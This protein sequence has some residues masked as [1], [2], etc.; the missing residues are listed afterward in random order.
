MKTRMKFPV[1]LLLILSGFA[2]DS[3]VMAH[4]PHD[5]IS[6]ISVSPA[7]ET[8]H[9]VFCT[10]RYNSGFIL[11][12]TNGGETWL[13]SQTGHPYSKL[14][15]IVLSPNYSLDGE[16]FVGTHEGMI[17]KSLNQGGSWEPC[18]GDAAYSI[19]VLAVSP[20]YA[21]DSVVLFGTKNHG[22]FMSSDG[23][24]TWAA[25]N[26][27]LDNK[28]IF[29][30][31]VSPSFDT[32]QTIFS[33]TKE[34]IFKS[35]DGG[36]TWFNPLGPNQYYHVKS[37]SVSPSYSLDQTLFAAVWGGGVFK[38][39]DGGSTWEIA[40]TGITDLNINAVDLSPDYQND[41]TLLVA[42][43]TDGIFKSTDGGNSWFSLNEG[44][45]EKSSQTNNHYFSFAFSPTYDQDQTVFLATWEGLHLSQDN[46]SKWRHLNIFNQNLVRGLVVSPDF[47]ND[48]TVFAATYGGGVY[49]TEDRGES[50]KAVDTGLKWMFPGALSIS[51][52]FTSDGTLFTGIYDDVMKSTSM[53]DEWVSLKI[54]YQEPWFYCKSLALSPNYDT[55]QT[56][57]AG[58]GELATNSIYKSIDGGDSFFSLS[59]QWGPATDIA[60]SPVYAE[61]Q[62]V[63]TGTTE[64]LYRSIDGGWQWKRMTPTN[65]IVT[66]LAVSP[67]FETDGELF[68]AVIPYDEEIAPG[69]YKST[70]RG[71][72]WFESS[73]GLDETSVVSALGI[74]P[75]YAVDRTLFAATISKG[76]YKSIDGG[77][78]WEYSGLKE[79]YFRK[80]ALSPNYQSDRTLFAGG[81]NGVYRSVDGGDTW[82]RVLNIHR[83]DNGIE[84]INYSYSKDWIKYWSP[85]AS[86]GSLHYS[87][88]A[89]SKAGMVF[90]GN[91]I[92]WIGAKGPIG[93]IANVYLDGIFQDTVD[94]YAPEF[95]WGVVLFTQDGLTSDP[96]EITIENTGTKNPLST[97]NIVV[98]DAFESGY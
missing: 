63:F 66:C 13:P 32:D 79:E 25:H 34:G 7:F 84:F 97:S 96:H 9:T 59:G 6:A 16:A 81:W 27:G 1:F 8:D 11:K 40:S 36:S 38:S 37:I 23:G 47:A 76:I 41:G 65:L 57:F 50:W 51:P 14:T 22:I 75:D 62:T 5:R 33:G 60:L 4:T 42:T 17:Y 46:T 85:D 3:L 87:E 45:D 28:Y 15:S 70:D 49:R 10:V 74:S 86:G 52:A 93:G 43:K 18:G 71:S 53:G 29:S 35:I 55:D 95:E 77:D 90:C 12:S 39:T 98:V 82:G 68:G 19:T 30:V 89:L 56:L 54:N 24:A 20:N 58:N 31:A 94:L 88:T 73:Y 21:L 92:S 26:S 80:L 44:L 48:E 64:G 2:F 78:S 61:D 91:S 83:Y 69:V 67:S 72:T